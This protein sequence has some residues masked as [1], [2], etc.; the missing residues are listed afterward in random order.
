MARAG[1][2]RD[3]RHGVGTRAAR[4]SLVSPCAC[5]YLRVTRSVGSRRPVP[6][7]ARTPGAAARQ[8]ARRHA[9]SVVPRR[10]LLTVR[11]HRVPRERRRPTWPAERAA[12]S[13]RPS[14]RPTGRWLLAAQGRLHE[15]VLLADEVSPRLGTPGSDDR[16]HW[17]NQQATVLLTTLARAL[18]EAGDLMTA[19]RYLLEVAVPA[20]QS[21]RTY[22]T[23]QYELACSVVWREEGDF[24][25]AEAPVLAAVDQFNALDTLPALAIARLAEARL[26]DTAPA[27][28]RGPCPVRPGRRRAQRARPATRMGGC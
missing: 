12:K 14:S 5:R 24:E 3:A 6:R 18:A 20:T 15:A 4:R 27:H 22:A 9:R 7:L 11:P 1:T 10:R 13:P 2:R 21:R 16:Q 23:A 25:R 17:A 28:G 19:E 26:A 8:P